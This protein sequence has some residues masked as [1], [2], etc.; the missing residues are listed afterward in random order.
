MAANEEI[1][2][3]IHEKVADA[4]LKLLAAVEKGGA[5]TDCG[6]INK[7]FIGIQPAVLSCINKFLLQ[8]NIQ[9]IP[10]KGSKLD[11]LKEKGKVV[12]LPTYEAHEK[13]AIGE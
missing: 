10:V 5:C 8:N 12:N 11:R 2:S 1:L 9:A 7:H 4:Y 6:A 3:E 13:R